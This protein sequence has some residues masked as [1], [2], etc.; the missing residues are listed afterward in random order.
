MPLVLRHDRVSCRQA[1][2]ASPF[3]RSEV[4]IEDGGQD[5]R[6]NPVAAVANGN[7]YVITGAHQQGGVTHRVFRADFDRASL[8][9]RLARIEQDVVQHLPYLSGV[10]FRRPEIV[11]N[12]K[13]DGDGRPGPRQ[14][15]RILEQFG[16][17]TGAAHRRSSLGKGQQL[18]GQQGRTAARR[19]GLLQ[20]PGNRIFRRCLHQ[21]QLDI[22]LHHGQEVIEVV[23]NA[24]RQQ[25]NR[26]Q[27]ARPQQLFFHALPLF[28]LRQQTCIGLP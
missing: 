5:L 22:S 4:G 23:R 14:A 15:Y 1:Q 9:H 7:P 3:F 25:A 27:L 16:Q 20:D 8:G 6:R 13:I 19:G 2:S 26:F 21:R 11:A 24:A 18:R 28:D 12:R 10:E 17:E